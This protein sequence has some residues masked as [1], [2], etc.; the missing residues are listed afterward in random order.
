LRY[1][2]RHLKKTTP[3]PPLKDRGRQ[4][5]GEPLMAELLQLLED[6]GASA[7]FFVISSQ[8]P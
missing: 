8:V 1:T 4:G 5:R 3:H 7:T 6:Y 2:S